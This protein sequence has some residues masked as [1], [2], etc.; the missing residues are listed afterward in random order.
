MNH[1]TLGK[2]EDIIK[3]INFVYV[4]P[5]SVIYNKIIEL[6]SS[7]LVVH[8]SQIFPVLQAVQIQVNWKA[9]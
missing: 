1:V 7:Y 4:K 6:E 9:V 2:L 8:W 3:Q 5:F